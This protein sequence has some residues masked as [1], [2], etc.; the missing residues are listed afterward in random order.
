MA[1]KRNTKSQANATPSGERQS[2]AQEQV[3]VQEEQE[4][5][6]QEEESQVGAQQPPPPPPPVIDLVQVMNNQTLLLEALANAITAQ[7]PAN[8]A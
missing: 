8:K 7:S 2:G 6:Q 3:H 5:S 4:V 1:P